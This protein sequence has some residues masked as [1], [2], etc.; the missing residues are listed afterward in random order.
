VTDNFHQR[1]SADQAEQFLQQAW[2]SGVVDDDAPA[3]I[4][5]DLGRM[6]ERLVH[7]QQT[8]PPPTLHALAIKANPLVEVLREAVA[9]GAGLEA[10]S[11]EEVELALAA[12]C[13][14]ER[15]VFDSP[16]KTAAEI[17]RTL[18]LGILLNANTLDELDRI[19]AIA[20]EL[21]GQLPSASPRVGLRVNPQVS[22]GTIAATSV[23][24]AGSKF[25]VRLHDQRDEI[26]DAYRRW[27]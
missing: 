22:A 15:I 20:E 17:R 23:G 12:D 13:P 27:S 25:G 16:A 6:R 8:F 7:L 3:W 5:H 1:L 18:G 26:F 19:G 2:L 4:V 11:I 10:A 9:C 14:R 21:A 24:H